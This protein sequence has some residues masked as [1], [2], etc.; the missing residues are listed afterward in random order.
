MNILFITLLVIV[1]VDI[2]L[3]APSTHCSNYLI[4]VRGEGLL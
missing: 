1:V 4:L 2:L 3:V